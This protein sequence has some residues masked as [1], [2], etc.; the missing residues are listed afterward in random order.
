MDPSHLVF[1]KS[2]NTLYDH[3]IRINTH[4]PSPALSLSPAKLLQDRDG[5]IS[6]RGQEV[7]PGLAMSGSG[8]V[9]AETEAPHST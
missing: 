7:G 5:V 9:Q 3:I 2:A 1:Q 8:H 4:M 6:L